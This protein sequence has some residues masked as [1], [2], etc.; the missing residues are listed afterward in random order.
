MEEK[1]EEKYH[2]DID[3]EDITEEDIKGITITTCMIFISHLGDLLLVV[4]VHHP[5]TYS[6]SQKL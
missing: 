2:F 1:E 4:G 3:D 5:S 6:S